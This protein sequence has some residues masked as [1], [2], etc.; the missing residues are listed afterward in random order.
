MDSPEEMQASV[1]LRKHALRV[2]GA[3]NTLVENVHD[4]EKTASVLKLVA[5]SH[6]VKHRVEP[7]YFKVSENCR[8]SASR[9]RSLKKGHV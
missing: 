6:A 7:T 2:M 9:S 8:V 1:Q 4:G 3:L 5:K